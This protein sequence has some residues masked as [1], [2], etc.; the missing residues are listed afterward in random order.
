[1]FRYFDSHE[2]SNKN[3]CASYRSNTSDPSLPDSLMTN[4]SAPFPVNVTE[5]ESAEYVVPSGLN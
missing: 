2:F 5:P 1:M 3:R 4:P